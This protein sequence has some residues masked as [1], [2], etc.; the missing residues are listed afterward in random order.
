MYFNNS[1]MNAA[2]LDISIPVTIIARRNTTFYLRGDIKDLATSLPFDFTDFEAYM[3]WKK[4]DRKS[5]KETP[6]LRFSSLTGDISFHNGTSEDDPSYFIIAKPFN[7]MTIEAGR[8]FYDFVLVD[9][10]HNVFAWT[11]GRVMLIQ[12]ITEI[13]LSGAGEPTGDA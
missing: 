11:K 8:Y 13:T 2:N 6:A 4:T 1:K 9:K 3:H 12:N 7:Q 5:E 10:S